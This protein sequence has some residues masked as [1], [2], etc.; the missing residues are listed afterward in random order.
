M[1]HQEI[2]KAAR[3][4]VEAKKSFYILALVFG[5]LSIIILLIMAF[6]RFKFDPPIGEYFWLLIPVVGFAL[7]L[8]IL[9]L[10]IFRIPRSRLAG[11]DNWEERQLK[12]EIQRLYRREG[13]SP[14]R[15]SKLSDEDRLELKELE[16]LK[17]KW[18]G[19]DDLV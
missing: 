4:K 8:G 9:Y 17:Q 15:E 10:S 14:P 6:I 1:T 11:D 18:E 19:K 5:A 12:V 3:K 16:R 7:V 2:Q 13:M